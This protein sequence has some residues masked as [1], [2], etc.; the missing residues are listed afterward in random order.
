MTGTTYANVLSITDTATIYGATTINDHLSVTGTTYANALSITDTAT[1]Y[2]ATTIYDNLSIT[3]T[4]T[5]GGKT[6]INNNLSV[7]GTIW[8]NALYITDTANIDFETTISDNLEVTGTTLLGGTTT[9]NDSLYVTGT[10]YADILNITNTALINGATTI[11]DSL[12]VTGTTRS[13]N[14]YITQT[15]TLAG[16]TT[17]GDSSADALTLNAVLQGQTPLFFEGAIADGNQ[18][19]III[20]E[21]TE[22][23]Q[24]TIPDLSGTIL[25]SGSESTMATLNVTGPSFLNEVYAYTTTIYGDLNMLTSTLRSDTAYIT[26]AVIKDL[27]VDGPS[28]VHISSPTYITNS[29]VITTQGV[30]EVSGPNG[31]EISSTASEALHVTGTTGFSG[32]MFITGT[33]S[34]PALSVSGTTQI[35]TATPFVFEGTDTTDGNSTT[36]ALTEPSSANTITIPNSSG[37]LVLKNFTKISAGTSKTLTTS[38]QGI[39]LVSSTLTNDYTIWL[40]DPVGQPGLTYTIKKTNASSNSVAITNSNGYKIDG[41]SYPDMKVQYAYLEIISDGEQW[42]KI[43]EYPISDT[44][45]V[46]GNSGIIS[47]TGSDSSSVTLYWTPGSD[48]WTEQDDLEYLVCVSQSYSSVDSIQECESSVY[49][50]YSTYTPTTVGVAGL[51]S[52]TTY[53]FNIVIKDE[54]DRKSLYTQFSAVPNDVIIYH[55]STHNGNFGGRTGADAICAASSNRPITGYTDYHALMSFDSTDTIGNMASTFSTLKQNTPIKSNANSVTSSIASNWADLEALERQVLTNSGAMP[56][57]VLWWSG[58]SSTDWSTYVD[59][60]D[61]FTSTSPTGVVKSTGASGDSGDW[62]KNDLKT[63]CANNYYIMCI[64]W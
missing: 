52:A 4:T 56:V 9:I 5:I 15:S 58:T 36:F 32:A 13:N 40:P 50:D 42:Y 27:V 10:V 21:P 26:N 37:S 14:L 8:A 35:Q 53:Y 2:G 62:L 16:N 64:G 45:P 22:A 28:T 24:I 20:A 17:I 61:G 63:S 30:F 47:T 51:I 33:T 31:M 1:I 7:T 34:N 29:V 46:P 18:T 49:A 48:D 54:V 57:G 38:D 6:T 25:L 59:S 11:N 60:C 44:V 3:G 23:R 43:G 41:I 12:T 39:V 19:T 55:A